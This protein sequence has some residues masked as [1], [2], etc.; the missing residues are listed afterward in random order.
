MYIHIYIIGGNVKKNKNEV[1][2]ILVASVGGG[3][4]VW[5]TGRRQ[6]SYQEGGQ[7]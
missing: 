4:W 7:K 3:V 2:E 5:H 1:F 6:E